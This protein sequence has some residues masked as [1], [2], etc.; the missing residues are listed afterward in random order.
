MCGCDIWKGGHYVN[1]TLGMNPPCGR[2][3]SQMTLKEMELRK[4]DEVPLNE[5]TS[6]GQPAMGVNIFPCLS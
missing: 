2:V 5:C 3:L 4:L 6:F 1:I